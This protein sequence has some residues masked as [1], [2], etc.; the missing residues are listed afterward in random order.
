MN[1]NPNKN[2][3]KLLT[4]SII[5]SLMLGAGSWYLAPTAL[6]NN[7]IANN[8]L[9]TGQ[10]NMQGIDKIKI[11][12]NTMDI[13]QNA[14]NAVIK[15]NDFSIGANATVNFNKNDGNTF[16]TLNYVDGKNSSQIYG[17]MNAADNG[18]I[19][20]VNPNGVQISNS[21][22]INVGS[23]Y[24]SNKKL[25]DA[26][27]ASFRSNPSD[28]TK[29]GTKTNAELMNLGN[30][31]ANNIT[32][33]GNRVVLD[34]DRITNDSKMTPSD[35]IDIY[36]DN[37]DVV[38]AS[39]SGK[40]AK[41]VKVNGNA[42]N[43]D[44]NDYNYTW[45]GN[46]ADLQKINNNLNKN[47]ALKNSIDAIVTKDWTDNNSDT[48][49]KGFKPI[50]DDGNAFT[51]K[52]DGLN[53]PIF[54][55]TINRN[56]TSDANIGLFGKTDGATL[57]NLNLI[58]GTVSGFKNTGGLVGSA[59]N[60]AIS[61]I[62]NTID[63]NGITNVG[64]VIG[65]ATNSQ[66]ENVFNNATVRGNIAVGG[67]VGSLNKSTLTG[68]SYNLGDVHG[69]FYKYQ[70]PNSPNGT[71]AGNISQTDM[72]KSDTAKYVGGL[73]GDGKDVTIGNSG[74]SENGI[75]Q[76][77]NINDVTAGSNVGGIAGRIQ[78]DSTIQNVRNEGNITATDKDSISDQIDYGKADIN[79][80][81]YAY[82]SLYL[83][84]ANAGGIV[85]KT[86]GYG[87][88]IEIKHALNKGTVQSV[89]ANTKK[90]IDDNGNV[91]NVNLT[92]QM[93]KKDADGNFVT[94]ADGNGV[95]EDTKYAFDGD[96]AG[97][98]GGIVGYANNT[99][100]TDATNQEAN[101]S[102]S[103]N[104]GGIVGHLNSFSKI[105]QSRNEGGTIHATGAIS[106]TSVARMAVN[107]GLDDSV[108]AN[109]G[110]V[111]GYISKNSKVASSANNGDV[112]SAENND[113]MIFGIG[114]I[115]G[116]IDQLDTEIKDEQ[117]VWNNLKQDGS[118]AVIYDSYN[119]GK[120]SGDRGVGGVAGAIY[121]GS[122]ANS[123][124]AGNVLTQGSGSIGGIVG[125]ARGNTKDNQGSILYNV[126][127]KGTI[128]DKSFQSGGRHI[129][130]IA[131]HFAGIVDT[132]FNTGDIYNSKA[133]VGG[134]VGWLP[135]GSI[136]NAYNTGNITANV[137]DEQIGATLTSVGGIVGGMDRDI[138]GDVYLQNLYNLGTIRALNRDGGSAVGVAGIVGAVNWSPG[139]TQEDTYFHFDHVYTT[140][141]IYS[142]D[143]NS[144]H[145]DKNY[146]SDRK[147]DTG[148]IIGGTYWNPKSF[149]FQNVFYILP[150]ANSD[151][152]KLNANM[153]AIG[154][155]IGTIGVSENGKTYANK[156][157]AIAYNDRYDKSSWIQ[158]DDNFFT[159]NNKIE[160][161]HLAVD[162]SNTIDTNI[163]DNKGA[164][165]VIGSG[166]RKYEGT[167]G[168]L[169]IL[170]V[171]RPKGMDDWFATGA[172]HDELLKGAAA[173]QFGN[174]YNPYLTFVGMNG[175]DLTIDANKF[176]LGTRDGI[177]SSN[178]L[179]INNFKYSDQENDTPLGYN[180]TLLAYDGDLNINGSGNIAFGSAS[181]LYGNSVNINVHN[182][183]GTS[184]SIRGYGTIQALGNQ[185][186]GGDVN[187][188][189]DI[190]RIIGNIKA[191]DKTTGNY[192][193]AGLGFALRN[194]TNPTEAEIKDASK[195]LPR[196]EDELAITNIKANNDGNITINASDKAEILAGNQKDSVLSAGGKMTV[197]GT[198][199][200]Y[201]DSDF[202]AV[203]GDVN[204]KSAKATLDI[205]NLS[206][207][208]NFLAKHQNNINIDS[209]D[210]ILAYNAWDGTQY[211]INNNAI[212]DAMSSS[213]K[214]KLHL[215]VAD[216]EQL[217][218]IQTTA[219]TNSDILN[220]NF[221]L[222]N[223]IK[224]I[225][226][227]DYHGIASGAGQA[228]TGTFNGRGNSIIDLNIDNSDANVGI[229]GTIGKAGIVKNLRV[230][231]INVKGI[232]N[233]NVGTIA[234]TNNG[235]IDG[236]TTWG[237]DISGR[238]N[239]GGLV[240]INNNSMKNAD[241][242]NIV[243]ALNKNANNTDTLGGIAGINNGDI[244][245]SQSISGLTISSG[246]A[247]AIGGIA[248]VNNKNIETV[249][250]KG[251]TSGI[252][253][254]DTANPNN[255]NQV[256]NPYKS[257]NVGGIVG[258]NNQGAKINGAYNESVVKGGNDVG[259]IVGI[260]EGSVENVANA[261]EITGKDNNSG[262]IAGINNNSIKN[263]RN[264]A[265]IIGEN[266]VGGL[267]GLNGT[268]SN[269]TTADNDKSA[270]ITG[271]ENV[272]GITG[273][274]QGTID[275]AKQQLENRGAI[276]GHQNVGGVA[277]TNEGKIYGEG[278]V[279]NMVLDVNDS[280]AGKAQNFG[281]IVGFNR[282]TI[283]G[284]NNKANLN[285]DK[286]TN[287]GGI[288]GQ[289]DGGNLMG[290]VENNGTVTGKNYVGGIGGY[291]KNFK[292][293]S[294]VQIVGN[295]ATNNGEV[296]SD[297]VAGGIMGRN[298]NY[299]AGFTLVN[300]RAVTGG[301]TVGGIIGENHGD[302]DH[303]SLYNTVN[304]T[305]SGTDNVG[306][307]IGTNYGTVMG[308][309]DTSNNFYQ[310]QIYNNG[311]VIATNNNAG[312]LIGNNKGALI[313]S[314]NTGT[315][316]GTQNVGGIVGI[317]TG[318]VD[319]V[320]NTLA[321]KSKTISGNANVGGII[322]QNAG[323]LSNAYNST[324][325]NGTQNVGNT[326]GLNTAKEKF[327]IS[328]E[329]AIIRI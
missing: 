310:Y 42:V 308:G 201:V 243:K 10:H 257:D 244:K 78:G 318:T 276:A 149:S 170:N 246:Y 145:A 117:T 228:Y 32:F 16:H 260:N 92:Y 50:G 305:V 90:T 151:L 160:Q 258:I 162:N 93:A 168:T 255:P 66:I 231:D 267:V 36:S 304:G 165:G 20:L 252:H 123:Y 21:A 280:I 185:A 186:S 136:Y 26:N 156:A 103:H 290:K 138:G 157:H 11:D 30:I 270:K 29:I 323:T 174:T 324:A 286:A 31:N 189:S 7:T 223:N 114:G 97:N 63:V 148:Y 239:I 314:Y 212:L 273:L 119:T 313:A 6:A 164:D 285:A 202:S 18:H 82:D 274:N 38:L 195:K 9:P 87:G 158:G 183:D 85:G 137:Y 37:N 232:N 238:G 263:A 147:G 221:A 143:D 155:S 146:A 328:M 41:N 19:Y 303:A 49:E 320:F 289:N 175:K 12:N 88:D 207:G 33:D 206:D 182:Q 101:I 181:A 298:D 133:L 61:N 220:Y 288:V 233:S 222:K 96:Y 45:I 281:G 169:P 321:D 271:N 134:I 204:I 105:E 81:Y 216:G 227:D 283:V 55:L 112:N 192:N 209:D 190:V 95:Y 98:V 173:V 127:N 53:Y 56:E 126:Y 84:S 251:T 40:V 135:Q 110:G 74:T 54:G 269:I 23:L 28:L 213:A 302:I 241:A 163:I 27:L 217:K 68:E 140:G 198:N 111:A 39:D 125:D 254:Y 187:I 203:N 208:A 3:H 24:V 59:N 44:E 315:V 178:N 307:I 52:F 301:D 144:N 191:S 266:N 94:D 43:N 91:V 73:V 278:L 75:F 242:N 67:L 72:I 205:S 226:V 317:N 65:T 104:V 76:M 316:K 106:G 122:I 325:V 306:G 309:R 196:I 225:D 210:G 234:G 284:A 292:F 166:W 300:N 272:G 47:Y 327:L 70:N 115:A 312:G 71:L 69:A 200:A 120:I 319:Q 248:G 46:I 1:G 4:E 215:W 249:V 235:L 121:N 293:D 14:T 197:S 17:R 261:M 79:K 161:T 153:G 64:G 124:N 250:N 35:S 83:N 152:A 322:G 240:G 80:N 297:G 279:N 109:A 224:A 99:T 245:T 199:E 62:K 193:L 130:G 8:T 113:M 176:H 89:L 142:T 159:G 107:S 57:K 256:E 295:T 2:Q 329:L 132:A 141:N 22:Q 236:S 179:T 296:I 102:G 265:S 277:G 48:Y 268:A 299:I 77:Y 326:V 171:F 294:S 51:G 86:G 253:D 5:L 259:G 25:S 15:W 116:R 214:A 275:T 129:G 230:D 100:I 219:N 58:G 108:M 60:T 150:D 154:G 128:G 172:N 264:N 311:D 262:G 188:N 194:V 13:T 247:N 177:I 287:V 218:G 291:N 180:G 131:G 211:N 34:V 184:A 229:F 118:T 139:R 167:A 282:G 237:G